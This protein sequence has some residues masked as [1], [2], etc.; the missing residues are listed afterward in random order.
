MPSISAS[1]PGYWLEVLRERGLYEPGV[2][3]ISGTIPMHGGVDQFSDSW[4]VELD[5][6]ATGETIELA[7]R[8]CRLPEAIG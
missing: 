1:T 8:V 3:L 5:D 7:C 4:R 2:V 6:P